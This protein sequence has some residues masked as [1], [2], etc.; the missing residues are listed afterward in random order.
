MTNEGNSSLAIFDLGGAYIQ[1][2]QAGGAELGSLQV[3][4]NA[5]IAGDENVS[6]SIGVGNSLQVAGN[7]T[8]GG[9]SINGIATPAAP[10]VT[11][12]GG[13]A[14]HYSYAI[15]AFNTSGSSPASTATRLQLVQLL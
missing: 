1:Q 10:T 8:L 3:D 15:A 14:T 13:S 9:L 12:T 6:G 11:P 2:L 7:A 4:T 5:Q